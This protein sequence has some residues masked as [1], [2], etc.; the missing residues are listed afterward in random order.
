MAIPSHFELM[1]PV[2]TVLSGSEAHV[3]D[4]LAQVSDMANLSDD[5]RTRMLPSGRVTQARSRVSW[6]VQYLLQAGAVDRLSRGLYAIN[7]RGRSLLES[8]SGGIT[9]S[10]LRSFPE[11]LDY[12]NKGSSVPADAAGA[13]LTAAVEESEALDPVERILQASVDL[14]AKVAADLVTLVNARSPA[15]LERVVVQLMEGMGYG[16]SGSTERLG[17]TGDEGV[18]GVVNQDALGLDKIYLQAKR[19]AAGGTVGR[20][21]VQAFVGAPHGKQATRGVFITTSRFSSEALDY[22]QRVNASVVLIDGQQLGRL[23][24]KYGIGVQVQQTVAISLL[25]EDFFDQL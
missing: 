19:Y 4:I 7:S 1:V 17:R 25:D 8:H 11:Y 23:M 15:F 3:R 22:A 10:D 18:D 16:T 13:E 9:D 14:D 24:V 20:P 5:D 21:D 2:L 6:A 12:K